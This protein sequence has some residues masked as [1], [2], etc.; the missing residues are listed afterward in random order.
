MIRKQNR[1]LLSL[2]AL[3]GALIALPAASAQAQ[4]AVLTG[5]VLSDVGAPLEAA[6]VLIVELAVSVRT[7]AQGQYSITIP[8]ARVQGQAVALRVRA[9]GYQQGVLGIR[10]TAGS[11]THDFEL[12]KDINRLSE[13]VV[14]GSMEGTE[15]A[16]VPFSVGRVTSEDLPVP[17]LDPIRALEGKVGGLRIGQTSGQPGTTPEILMRGPTSINATGRS[18]APMIIVDGAIQRVGSLDEIGGLDI[19]SVEVVKGAAGSSLYGSSAANGVIII[20]TKRG[21]NTDGI[22]WTFR[23]EGG[24]SDLN[25]LSYGMPVNFHM[26]LDETGKRFCVAGSGNTAPCS[27]TFD[28]M[29]EIMR[30]N[31][32]AAD[33]VRTLQ[34]AQFNAPSVAGGELL[35]VF[36]SNIWPNQYYNSFA[37]VASQNLI[38]LNSI[39]ANGKAGQVRY[40]ISGAQTNDGGAIKG[41]MGQQQ[42]RAR[43]N[44]DYNPRSDMTASVS[45]LFDKGTTDLR[46][47]GSSNGGIWGQ[48]LRGAPAG[49]DYL[50][51]DT[52]GRLLVQGGGANL[53]GSGNGA[54]TLLYDTENAW[55]QRNSNRLLGTMS[56]TYTPFDWATF[57]GTFAYD[58]RNRID[59]SWNVK[60]YR[61]IGV[62][63]SL[64]SGNQQIGNL[65]EEAMN[66]QISATFRNQIRSDLSAKIQFRG[67]WDQDYQASTGETGQIYVVKD[68]YTLSNTTTNKTATGSYST[69]KDLGGIIGANLEYKGRYIFDG[70]FRY[71]GSSLF[72]AGKRWA[73]FGRVSGVWRISEE[74]WYKIKGVSDLRFRASIGT[75]GNTP[76]FSAQYETYA[77]STS[78]C[79]LGQ[80]GN[81]NLK[82]E[83]T[84]E[85]EVGL[86]FT[87]FDRIG[88]EIT[89][90]NSETR[91][92]I[93]NVTTPSSLGFTSQWQ[94]AG[95]LANHT[96]EIAANIPLVTKRDQQ[97]SMRIGYDRTRTYITELFMPEYFTSAGTSQGT[98]SLFLITA[99]TDKQDGEQVNRYGN[100]WGRAFY[101][102]CDQMPA[103]VQASCGSGKDYQVNSQGYVVWVGA[104]NTVGDGITKNLWQTKL[105]QANSPW[106]YPLQ[107]GMPIID[108][109]LRGQKGEGIGNLHIIGNTLPDYRMQW[110]STYTYKKLSVYALLDA[111]MGFK[112]Q[113]QGEGW[114]LLDFSSSNFDQGGKSVADAKPIGY[115]WRVGGAEGAGVGGFYDILGPNNYNTEDGSYAKLREVNVSYHFGPIGRVGDWTFALIGRNLHTFTKYSGYDPETGVSGGQ[116]GSG[117]INAVDAFNF[118]TLRTFTLSVSTRF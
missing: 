90:A 30:I 48:I 3:F 69:I 49:T 27:R 99:R 110:S 113:N 45:M 42:S 75:A 13:V 103:S 47:G 62:S 21:A 68:V 81:K 104:G 108:R 91:N 83:T 22:K 10:V 102:A 40:F 87:L 96:W 115:S 109:P 72:G 16:K 33:T 64:N 44:I 46:S 26:Q 7:N 4:N 51:R 57:E 56:A 78:G 105:S 58:N 38:T 55:S 61:S 41:L 59:N 67:L 24:I 95:T 37:Q 50:A 12:K 53:R 52:L 70:T 77:C 43:V 54:G 66:A 11:Q 29:Q 34:Q 15:R 25:S 85:K 80:A 39:E 14:T 82:P 98:G 88:M 71:D 65:F 1:A 79:S 84:N 76:S 35:N 63:T 28:W 92:Q 9:I 8:A 89:N 74:P 20:K 60:G 93:L 112:I 18:Q 111:T 86:D 19:E 32:V 36:Q 97:W 100:I 6:N 106:N 73:P 5:K 94:N 118:P 107:W 2:L 31:N 114:G 17:A 23:S 116:A 101:K 117:L